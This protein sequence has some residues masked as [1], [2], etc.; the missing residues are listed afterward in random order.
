MMI[1]T[2][3]IYYNDGI[4]ADGMWGFDEGADLRR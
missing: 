4:N 1:Y 2:L 3:Y